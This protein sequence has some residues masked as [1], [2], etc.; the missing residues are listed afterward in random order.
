MTV[1]SLSWTTSS[2]PLKIGVDQGD[3]LSAI[4]FNSVMSTLGESLKQYRQLGYSFSNSSR[5]ITTLQYADDTCLVAD[6]PSSCQELLNHVDRWL[7][8]SGMREKVPKCYSLTLQASTARLYDPK[9][10][11]QGATVPFIGNNPVKFLGAFIQIPPDQQRMKDHIDGKLLSHLGKVDSAPV[12]RNQKLLLYK[13]GV[14]PRM[15]WDM[16]ISDLSISWVTKQLKATVTRYLKKWSGISRSV[17]P[18][19]L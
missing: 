13:A 3:P 9:L 17:D 12:T 18:S 15:L 16:G 10:T 8:W 14:C 2:I 7:L 19:C 11:L 6:G 5:S 1:V 4:I